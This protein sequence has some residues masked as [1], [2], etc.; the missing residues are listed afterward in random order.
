MSISTHLNIHFVMIPRW[1]IVLFVFAHCLNV[2]G[3]DFPMALEGEWQKTGS[4]SQEYFGE[5]LCALGDVNGDGF[6]D[7]LVGSSRFKFSTGKV[8]AFFGSPNGL[9]ISPNW[10]LVG[11]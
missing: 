1:A 3:G 4:S 10:E 11:Q 7:I 6:H 5:A 9:S 8:Q 2:R